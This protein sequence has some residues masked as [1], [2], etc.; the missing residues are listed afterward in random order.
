MKRIAAFLMLVIG[1]TIFVVSCTTMAKKEDP[2]FLGNYPSQ[3]LGRARLNV[4]KRYS[5]IL[6]P[7]DVSFV[8]DPQSNTVKF[9]HKMLGDNIWIYL[10]KENRVLFKQ[11]IEQYLESF[12]A[13]TLTPE[14]AKKKGR[15]GKTDVFMTW[16]IAGSA[17]EAY[18]V[19]RFDYQFITPQRPYFIL[20]NATVEGI[21]GS[22][23]PAIRIAVS[24]AQCQDL[25]KLL[26]ENALLEIVAD[27]KAEYEKFDVLPAASDI[28]AIERSADDTETPA[29]QEDIPFDNF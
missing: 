24:P 20:A 26:D 17:H 16:G 8:F 28:N 29:K 19:L 2:D 12:A 3:F 18:P 11:A 22:N 15:F 27:L 10:T 23:C 13:R 9:H 25:I 7:R 14:D 21:D 4:V 6:L 5:D 1:M